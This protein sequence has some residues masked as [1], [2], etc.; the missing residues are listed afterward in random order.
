LEVD[1]DLYCHSSGRITSGHGQLTH[2]PIEWRSEL[3]NRMLLL[4]SHLT[5]FYC[6]ALLRRKTKII[7]LPGAIF[8]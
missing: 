8:H 1:F 7:I 2:E 3:C 5:I 6:S 4:N